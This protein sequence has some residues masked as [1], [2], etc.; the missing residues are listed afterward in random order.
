MPIARAVPR[1]SIVAPAQKPFFLQRIKN[2]AIRRRRERLFTRDTNFQ[3]PRVLLPP[4]FLPPLSRTAP[5]PRRVHYPPALPLKPD[6]NRLPSL[7]LNSRRHSR[8]YHAK[9]NFRIFCFLLLHTCLRRRHKSLH[10]ESI[11]PVAVQQLRRTHLVFPDNA[12]N[13]RQR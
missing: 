9:P 13:S 7:K 12:G 2:N 10:P 1:T 4:A 5:W 11:R 6:V 8:P 3:V